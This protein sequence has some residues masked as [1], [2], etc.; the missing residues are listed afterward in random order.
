MAATEWQ[1]RRATADDIVPVGGV[2]ARAFQE[3]PMWRWALGREGVE[4]RRARL[5]RFFGAIARI[6]HARDELTF[7]AGDASTTTGAS[8]DPS[9]GAS[10]AGASV[11]G[12]SVWM[13]PGKWR[14]SLLDE[15]RMAPS[16]LAAFGPAGTVRLLQLLGAVE[17][18]HLREP[19]YYLFAIGA[20]PAHQGRGVGAAL[21]APMLARCDDEQLPAYLE[22]SN[23]QNLSFYR[24]HGFDDHGDALRFGDGVIV[25][26]MR[27]APRRRS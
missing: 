4:D 3:D 12:A 24:R 20:D 22:S 7:T 6:V 11:A 26:P 14:F 10:V 2:L 27:R 5:E 18:A 13:S 21:L 19:H 16:V 8:V 9:T 23:P 17:R 15:A 25:T 1:T